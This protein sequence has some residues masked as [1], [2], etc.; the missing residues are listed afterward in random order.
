[1]RVAGAARPLPSAQPIRAVRPEQADRGVEQRHLDLLAA[2]RTRAL[3]ERHQQ[4]RRGVEPRRQVAHRRAG[5]EGRPVRG[6]VE[7]RQSAHRLRHRVEARHSG[8]RP[9]VAEPGD[10]RIDQAGEARGQDPFVIQ[11]PLLHPAGPEVLDQHVGA[12]EQAQQRR[13]P[14]RAAQVDADA[15]LAAV[16]AVEIGALPAPER[17]PPGAGLVARRRLHLD[18]VGAVVGEQ[19]G[20]ERPRENA[21]E[22]DD[23]EAGERRPRSF[24][25]RRRLRR[26]RG[27]AAPSA[28]RSPSAPVMWTAISGIA[29]AARSAAAA[30][31]TNRPVDSA[32]AVIASSATTL[33]DR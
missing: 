1:M 11:A 9:V 18:H 4:P 8:H 12:L 14:G 21:G 33:T 20:A 3:H 23:P 30:G 13:A 16:E 26:H 31:A 2:P 25:L 6:A 10:A 28:R 22:V 32:S 29:R 24:R 7:A 5:A 27:Q 15:G 19:L 17:R